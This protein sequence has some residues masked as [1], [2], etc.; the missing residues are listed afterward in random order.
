M[1]MNA[2]T[3]KMQF[4]QFLFLLQDKPNTERMQL[5]STS[6]HGAVAQWTWCCGAMGGWGT[7]AITMLNHVEGDLPQRHDVGPPWMCGDYVCYVLSLVGPVWTLEMD[8]DFDLARVK[9]WCG[10]G[11]SQTIFAWCCNDAQLP[12]YCN[13]PPPPAIVFFLRCD[14]HLLP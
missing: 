5:S 7:L 1:T 14:T 3:Q 10:L 8:L 13:P 4:K 2:N 9:S 11:A 12:G 6:G